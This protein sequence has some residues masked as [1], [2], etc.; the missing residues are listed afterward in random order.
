MQHDGY[1]V[2]CARVIRLEEAA[3]DDLGGLAVARSCAAARHMVA[4]LVLTPSRPA[5]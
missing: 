5:L 3:S 1:G 2:G 4:M